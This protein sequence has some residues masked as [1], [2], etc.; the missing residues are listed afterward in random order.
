[1]GTAFLDIVS[2]DLPVLHSPLFVGWQE[3]I[4]AHTLWFLISPEYVLPE[5]LR[6]SLVVNPDPQ[7]IFETR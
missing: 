3:L 6:Q 4:A 2:D 1:M 7:R 5:S